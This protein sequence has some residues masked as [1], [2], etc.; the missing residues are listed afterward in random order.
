MSHTSTAPPWLVPRAAYVHVPFCGHKCGYCDFAV[1]A[2]QDHLID[3]YV[4]AVTA[5][6]T[7]LGQPQP[8]ESLFIGGGTP[9]YLA[10]T[11]LDR[12]LTAVCHWFPTPDGAEVSIESTPD[13]LDDERGRV[14]AA[15]GVRRV[16]VGV[17]SF[18][19]HT[20]TALDRRHGVAQISRAVEAVRRHVPELSFDLI[21]AAPGQTL[22][23]WQAD[24]V[25]ALTLGPDHIST[26]GLTYEAGT[27]LWQARRKGSVIAVP[28]DDELTMYL[29]GIDTLTAAG[30]RH[31]EVSNFARPD[32]E[33]VHNRRYWANEAYYGIGVGAARYVNGERAVNTRD[34]RRYIRTVL[35]SDDPTVQR[36]TLPPRDRAA[37]T[38]ATQLRRIEGI[39]RF[40]FEQ[41]TGFALDALAGSK[42][43]ALVAA[44]LLADDTRSVHLTRR[45]LCVADGVIA[46]L[47]AAVV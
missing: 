13:S 27:P 38:M 21:F 26:Y 35:A 3:L 44:G 15:H 19:A 43:M 14:L 5:E 9:T 20:L 7:R 6:L 10:P 32:R 4:E 25:A 16:S 42:V 17:Q 11:Q 24:L 39:D 41:Q 18:Q 36:E 46:E 22:S 8:V 45:G 30:F 47:L 33:S 1:A 2:G 34:T 40:A 12:L 37:E 28:E 23:D 29:T 31:Y